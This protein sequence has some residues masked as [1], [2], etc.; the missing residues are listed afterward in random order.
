M[1]CTETMLYVVRW[2][3]LALLFLMQVLNN[4]NFA[5]S[6]LINNFYVSYFGVSY[7]AVDWIVLAHFVGS[8]AATPIVTVLVFLKLVRFRKLGIVATTLI[9]VASCAS[10]WRYLIT[11]F[12]F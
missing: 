3:I 7:T 8:I 10:W 11:S 4:F 1:E 6:G 12:S 5:G 9:V 2:L